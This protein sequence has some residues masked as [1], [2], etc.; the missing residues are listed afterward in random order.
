M[1]YA[2]VY[3]SRTGNT[4]K[5]AEAVRGFLGQED[6]VYFGPPDG[7]ALEA[8]RIFAG[9]WTDKGSCDEET[10]R[11]LKTLGGREVFLFG[12]AGFGGDPGYFERI[13]SN[14]KGNLPADAKE[15]GCYMCQGRMPI[16]V[17]RRYEAMEGKPGAPGNLAAM[18]ENFDRALSHPDQA[19]I[20]GLLTRVRQAWKQ[21]GGE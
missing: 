5:L 12:T 20:D 17:R 7:R 1:T 9:F 3:S 6:C 15:A 14:V 18:I 21:G 16:Q 19:D 8:E 13:L 4:E 11:F 10:A 2:I